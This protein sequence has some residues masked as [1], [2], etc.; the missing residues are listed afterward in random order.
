MADKT[1]F[2]GLTVLAPGE[3]ISADNG[4][5]TSLNPLITDHFL[6][7]GARTHRH[8]AAAPLGNPIDAP[9][10]GTLADGG[11]IPADLAVYIGYT[12]MDE[13]NGETLLSPAVLAETDPGLDRP[14]SAP[15]AVA[16]YTAGGMMVDTYYYAITWTDATGGETPLGPIVSVDRDPGHANGRILLSGLTEGMDDAVGVAGWR[17]YRAT[18]G[19]DFGLLAS[20]TSAED[21]FNDVGAAVVD[22]TQL[23]PT[24]SQNTTGSTNRLRVTLPATA[25]GGSVSLRLYASLDGS[26]TDGGILGTYDVATDLGTVHDFTLLEVVDARP[27]T[28]AT[29]VGGASKIDPE[30]EL[31]NWHWRTPVANI[32]SLPPAGN[33]NGDV[34]LA[35][36]AKQLYMWDGDSWEPLGSA[37]AGHQI[38]DEGNS[39][40]D[41]GKLDFRGAGVAVSDDAGTDRTVVTISGGGGGGDPVDVGALPLGS[42]ITWVDADDNPVVSVTGRQTDTPDERAVVQVDPWVNLVGWDQAF[43]GIFGV[44][45]G[46]L[47]QLTDGSTDGDVSLTYGV[48]QLTND[49]HAE[50]NFTDLVDGDWATL[51]LLYGGAGGGVGV[52]IDTAASQLRI[53]TRDDV[54]DAWTNVTTAAIVGLPTEGFLLAVDYRDGTLSAFADWDAGSVSAETAVAQ[55]GYI[56][57]HA[58]ADVGGW[59]AST[60]YAS[61][62]F[63]W[64]ELAAELVDQYSSQ[65]ATFIYRASGDTPGN[66]YP[67]TYAIV[68]DEA[69]VTADGN[70]YREGSRVF[71]DAELTPA[72]DASDSLALP[73]PATLRPTTSIVRHLVDI[74]G[75]VQTITVHDT[76]EITRST[77]GTAPIPLYLNY[78]R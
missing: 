65:T 2:A 28:T 63:F 13:H 21:T 71:I 55:T 23:P 77:T 61:E 68:A 15:V 64:Y 45:G 10:V 22:C 12:L 29:T 6:E 43:P 42:P 67:S 66:P 78:R 41:R 73:L 31:L 35:L 54:N 5:F 27:P 4:S 51:G 17:L 30:T 48:E 50:V 70:V 72:N 11:A 49:W 26:F 39:K 33:T 8:N 14:D 57:I 24:D 74:D 37:A 25:P 56:C 47:V 3:P 59:A 7:I 69:E 1:L 38:L 36:A 62:L 20:G 18:G 53:A 58:E 9:G 52:F 32:A 40:P 16:D 44:A 19:A 34:R 75:D 60:F 76:G 46:K